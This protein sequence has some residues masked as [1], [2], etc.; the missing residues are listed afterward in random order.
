MNPKSPHEASQ[1]VKAI[2]KKAGLYKNIKIIIAPPAIYLPL[3][4]VRG[5]GFSAQDISTE[6]EGPYTGQISAEMVS[7]CKGTYTILG[8]SERRAT[9]ETNTDIARK[10]RMALSSKI[11]PIVCIGEKDRTQGMWHLG[12]VKTQ[13]EECFS[14]LS[15]NQLEQIVIAYE[16]VWAISSTANRQ[17]ATP[18][19]YEEMQLYIRKILADMFSET[20][21]KN[22]PILYGGSVN[23]K[24]VAGFKEAGA[25]GFLV[26]KASLKPETFIKI[27]QII[28]EIS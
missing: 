28:N 13:I 23:E 18:H 14:G 5:L 20:L 8:H 1:I 25:Q 6:K 16:P 15:K 4:A 24:N 26:G 3:L 22:I 9:G 7:A 19:D 17:D 10:I 21:A 27:A 2:Q 12:E 11:T